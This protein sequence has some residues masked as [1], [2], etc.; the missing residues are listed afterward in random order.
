[1]QLTHGGP[2]LL[3]LTLLDWESGPSALT[4]TFP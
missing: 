3:P 4:P 1:M 2:F